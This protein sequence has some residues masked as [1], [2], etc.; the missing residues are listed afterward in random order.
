MIQP[1]LVWELAR[2]E[3]ALFAADR[4]GMLLCFAVPVV[5]AIVFGAVFHQPPGGEALR[6]RVWIV[7]H[8]D[9]AFTARVVE[10]LESSAKMRANAVCIDSVRGGRG[11]TA[12]SFPSPVHAGLGRRSAGSL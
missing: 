7:S 1:R 8:D 12:T 10:A 4:R 2:K 11:G 6:P 3:L 9:S 5:L